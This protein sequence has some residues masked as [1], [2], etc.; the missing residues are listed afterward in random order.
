M[1][2]SGARSSLVLS[3]LG[4]VLLGAVALAGWAHPNAPVGESLSY[5]PAIS[6]STVIVAAAVDG[7]NPCAFTVL[8]LLVTALLATV[9]SDATKLGELRGRVM[10]RGGVFVAAIFLTYLALGV[11]VMSTM[12]LFTRQHWPARIAALLAVLFGLW[13]M[14]DYFLPDSRWRLRA[15][16]RVGDMARAAARKGTVPAL[17]VGGVLIGICTVPCSGAV[18]LAVLSLLTLQT[19]RAVGY[20]YLVLYNVIFVL[21]LILL[22]II[23]AARPNLRRLATWNLRHGERVRLILGGAVVVGGLLILATV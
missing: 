1:A 14:K 2:R 7:I 17:V 13:M 15:P 16:T 4:I 21:P 19:S 10:A 18:Y 23:A 5:L 20:G 11:G 22:L 12:G 3:G 9:Q 6:L 8:L